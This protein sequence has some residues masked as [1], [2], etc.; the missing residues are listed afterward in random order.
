MYILIW[1]SKKLEGED[2]DW[3]HLA[4]DRVNDRVL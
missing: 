2:V 1:I 3:I 4:A